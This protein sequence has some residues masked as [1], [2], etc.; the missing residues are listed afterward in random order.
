MRV[1]VCATVQPCKGSRSRPSRMVF[2]QGEALKGCLSNRTRYRSR[3]GRVDPPRPL[4]P[5][6]PRPIIPAGLTLPRLTHR[7][8]DSPLSAHSS[9]LTLFSL[10]PSLLSPTNSEHLHST[11]TKN[12]KK[13]P[14]IIPTYYLAL[15]AG[16]LALLTFAWGKLAA[17]AAPAL[18]RQRG[19]FVSSV[20]R[21]SRL[22][23]A[24]GPFPQGGHAA[25]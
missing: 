2:S 23:M 10:L 24:K 12:T 6:V 20:Q 17:P 22:T 18:R 15:S 13:M 9:F 7:S 21:M 4:K 11:Q 8:L 19:R 25:A 1:A 3:L 5:G 14:G 16:N